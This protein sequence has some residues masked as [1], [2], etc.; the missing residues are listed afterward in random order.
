MLK[1][2]H[3]ESSINNLKCDN[4]YNEENDVKQSQYSLL[5][6]IGPLNVKRWNALKN[7]LKCSNDED[8]A[9]KLLDAAEEYYNRKFPQKNYE[10]NPAK[11]DIKKS[12]N[13]NRCYQSSKN[14]HEGKE[15]GCKKEKINNCNTKENNSPEI[16]SNVIHQINFEERTTYCTSSVIETEDNLN[17]CKID[18]FEVKNTTR[19]ETQRDPNK[20]K[21][22]TEHDIHKAP[23]ITKNNDKLI[24]KENDKSCNNLDIDKFNVC[25]NC[26]T[27]HTKD[28]CPIYYPHYIVKDSVDYNAWLEKYKPAYENQKKSEILNDK[29]SAG[30]K[31]TNKYSFAIMSVPNFLSFGETSTNHGKGVFAKNNVEPFSRF[32][33]LIGKIIKEV[34]IPEDFSMKDLW[35]ISSE[36]GNI[37]FNTESVELSNWLKYIRPAPKRE[38]RNV[39]VISKEKDLYFVT[40][41][42]V[43]SGEELLYWQDSPISAN[44]KKMEKTTCGG[45]NMVFNHPHYYRIHCSVFHDLRYSLTIRKYHCKI[46]GAAVLGKENIMKHAAELHNGQGAYQCQFCKKFFLRLNYLE[47]HRTYGC[48]ANPHRSRPLCDFCGRK[49]CQ[50]QKL[51]VHIKRMHSDFSEVLK[52]FQCKSCLKILGSRA[53]LQRHSKEVHQKQIDG[54]CSCSRCG[55]KFQNKS[56]LKI[57]MLTHSGIKPFKCIAD[58]CKA[59]FTTKQCL[60]FHYKKVHNFTEDSMPKIKRSVEYTFQ[61]YSGVPQDGEHKIDDADMSK[62]RE[63]LNENGTDSDNDSMESQSS[64]IDDPAP[65]ESS[66][67]I[68]D[69]R[70]PTPKPSPSLADTYS[71]FNSINTNMKVLSKGSKKWIAGDHIDKPP[72]MYAMEKLN[73]EELTGISLQETEI[74]NRSKLN[75]L[76]DFSRH[77]ASNASLLVEAAL[78]SVC[79]EPNID[80]DVNTTPNCTDSLVNNLYTLTQPENLPDVSYGDPSCISESRDINLMS[81]SVN[82]HVSVTDELNNELHHTG[83]IRMD[84]ANFHQEDFSP[85]NSP[86]VSR[87]NFV[88]NYINN[89]SPHNASYEQKNV[90]PVPSPPR[91]DFGHAVN[92]DHLSSDDS[93]GMAAQNL[94]LHNPKND[95]QLDLSLYKTSYKPDNQNYMRRLKFE[96]ENN[97]LDQDQLNGINQNLSEIQPSDSDHKENS[98]DRPKYPDDLTATDIRNKFEIDLDLRLKNYENIDNEVLRQRNASYDNSDSD[99]RS[100]GYDLIEAIENRNK[101]YENMESD[102]RTD[103]NFE[104]LLLNSELQGLDMSA[105][106][107]HSYSNINR[108]HHLYPEVDRVDLRLSYSPPLPAY[109]HADILR[110][111]SLDLTPPGRHSVDL[112]LRTHP[113]HQIANSRLLTEHGLQGTPHRLLDQGRL[114]TADLSSSRHL[115]NDGR[116]I[117]ETS[118]RILSEHTTSRIL[119]GNEQLT[120]NHLLNTDQSRLMADESRIISDQSRILDQGRLIGEGRILQTATPSGVVSPVQGFSGYSVTQSPY[121]PTPIAPRPHVSSPTPTPYHHYSSYY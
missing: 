78:D 72:D 42:F 15:T 22:S 19:N 87:S 113:L 5:N 82:D 23:E 119:S 62:L 41:K 38:E 117:S 77:E 49:F 40:V 30:L 103:R 57:H 60:Q 105:R 35:E 120:T 7:A 94:S 67:Q 13:K 93:N 98:M 46:C 10:P 101:Q 26:S 86:E 31:E 79:S 11:R 71:N 20:E 65:L 100:K 9:T 109:T 106:G 33:P 83:S 114:L 64:N 44:K 84:Y 37:Y 97:P 107:F 59:A 56:N 51:K 47:M 66:P 112:S 4:N 54:A 16:E 73:K 21:K 115:T 53:A 17:K 99:F 63:P 58:N 80:I 18:E 3:K 74:Y 81:P 70:P 34:D 1:K 116:M 61:A 104:P 8:F 89:L 102:F 45:C 32:G 110:V 24:G 96:G 88:R 121:H 50:P 118:G 39:T 90:S 2:F 14:Q 68:A 76:S 92:A 55:K 111:V 95:I 28:Q 69:E 27:C 108:Y 75:N 85:P 91:Y 52:E 25:Q 48:S 29:E 43:K 12:K 36:S 6:V